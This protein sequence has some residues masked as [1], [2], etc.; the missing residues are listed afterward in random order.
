MKEKCI[1]AGD[2]CESVWNLL[3][4]VCYVSGNSCVV[5]DSTKCNKIIQFLVDQF[6]EFKDCMCT[7]D[8]C[9]VKTF[10]VKEC[11]NHQ[12]QPE[13][14]LSTLKFPQQT[15]SEVTGPTG[16]L[17]RNDCFV[18]K[19]LCRGDDTCSTLYKNFL[20][21][22]RAET[23]KCSLPM[24]GQQCFTAWKEL[25]RTILGNCTCPEPVQ[26]RCT[27]IWKNI[28]NNT[29]LDYAQIFHN[30]A[31]SKESYTGEGAQNLIVDKNALE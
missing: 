3:E 16:L 28:F 1:T 15:K 7:K 25:Q 31:M 4:D 29:C 6:S 2:E 11:S 27:K 5:I 12:G 20:R 10:Q 21:A 22:C 13:H 18:A 30:P 23:A 24:A 8:N 9:S 14:S 26:R 17:G 19:E